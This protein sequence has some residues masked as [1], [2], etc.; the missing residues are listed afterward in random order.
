MRFVKRLFWI[1]A[2]AVLV[3]VGVL[4]METPVVVRIDPLEIMPPVETTLAVVMFV[5]LAAGVVIGV[6]LENSRGRPA[7]RQLSKHH[8]ELA[9][10]RGEVDRLRKALKAADHPESVSVPSVR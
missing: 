3:I 10:L 1:L 7:R 6:L 2:L 4:N 5:V 8:G 9:M